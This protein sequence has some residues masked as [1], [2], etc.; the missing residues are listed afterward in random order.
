MEETQELT[1]IDNSKR[2][3]AS[4]IEQEKEFGK[5]LEKEIENSPAVLKTS[6]Q[7]KI[8]IINGQKTLKI[9]KCAQ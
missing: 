6:K 8:I 5:R 2:Q 1:K 3:E 4:A 7:V 9:V